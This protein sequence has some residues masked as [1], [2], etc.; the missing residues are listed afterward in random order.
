M[1]PIKILLITQARVGSTRFPN[2]IT[3][4]LADTTLLG[5]HLERLKK[6]QLVT[7]FCVATT[8]EA[9]VEEIIDIAN[10]AGINTFQ[11]SLND[12]LD[13][14][15][16][17]ALVHKPRYVVRVT[18]DCPL[19]DPEL[20]D[21]VISFC[22]E[23]KTDYCSNMIVEE[24]PDGQDVEVFT[25]EALEKAWKEAKLPSEREHVTP[26][27]RN[28]SDIKGGNLFR[29]DHFKAP[30]NYNHVRMTVDEPKDLNTIKKLV[31]ILGFNA[32][33]LAYTECI[34]NNIDEFD[35]QDIT[36]NEGYL[37]SLH[38]DKSIK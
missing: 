9:G 33:W 8:Q 37:K 24:Y 21:K 35:N 15:Y 10:H 1:E 28:N 29:A 2:K 20:I 36:R 12:V 3:Q 18:S 26:Y 31:S 19:L 13:R 25:F 22:V 30:D 32:T 27:I 17:A 4:R 34:I 5:L 11:G 6:A 14:F 7:D 16:Q 38:N 23:S